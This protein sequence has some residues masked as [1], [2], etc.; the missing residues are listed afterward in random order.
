MRRAFEYCRMFDKPIL[1]HEEVLE[2]SHGG[3]MNEG[4]VS[5]SLGLK[6]M[7][8]AAE[9]V[10]IGRDIALADVTGGRL[11]VMHVSTAHGVDL[12]REAK[13]RGVRVTAEA[14]PHHFTLTDE[15]L[16][17]FDSNF[18]MTH[19]Y[20][21]QKMSKVFLQGLP[22]AHSTVLQRIT[23]ACTRRNYLSLTEHRLG[24]LG[25]KQQSA[26]P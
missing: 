13:S 12:I 23:A 11:H 15:S 7:P 10:M 21:R 24:F 4:L 22:M 18:K 17:G 2:L 3:V 9:E 6:G 26:F 1:A 8:A 14:C 5:M 25:W 19:R 20:E 16:R